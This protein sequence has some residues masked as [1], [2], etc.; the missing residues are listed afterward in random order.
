M[1]F[2]DY[3]D[4]FNRC[5]DAALVREFWTEDCVMDSAGR[6]VRG[7]DELLAFL[8][9]A[10][11]G[12]QEIMRPQYVME[13]G[14]RIFAE[15]DMD[16]R[17]T[18]DRPDFVFGPLKQGEYLTVKFFAFYRTE[19]GK[20]AHLKTMTWPVNDRVSKPEPRLGAG[21]EARQAFYDYTRAFSEARFDVFPQY[22]TDDVTCQLGARTLV[23]KQGIIDFYKVMF[24]RVRETIIVHKVIMDDGGICASITSKFTAIEDATDF[25]PMPLAKGAVFGGPLYVIY[26]LRDGKISSITASRTKPFEP[27]EA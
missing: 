26:T 6:T 10:H 1:R 7:R 3:F 17:A 8:N 16:F 9:W 5:D 25:E 15:I 23:G 18:R 24:E 14:D 4:A 21:L 11:D 13:E 22:Y 27:M 2:A 20:V 19:G 12:I